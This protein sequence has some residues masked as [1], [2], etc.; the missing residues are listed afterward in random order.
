MKIRGLFL[1]RLL[2]YFRFTDAYTIIDRRTIGKPTV[3]RVIGESPTSKQQAS[4]VF[5]FILVP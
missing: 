2:R 4:S 5:P 3:S 1:V